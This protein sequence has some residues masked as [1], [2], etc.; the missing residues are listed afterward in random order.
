VRQGNPPRATSVARSM[1]QQRTYK[2]IAV[3]P[4]CRREYYEGENDCTTCR[5][6]RRAEPQPARMLQGEYDGS[7]GIRIV[8]YQL[9]A[10]IAL[11]FVVGLLDGL[12]KN[13]SPAMITHLSVSL[14]VL[15]VSA[16]YSVYPATVL[17]LSLLIVLVAQGL[18]H[19]FG[20]F[21]LGEWYVLKLLL[22][23]IPAGGILRVWLAR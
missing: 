6:E 12:L 9:Y 1:E 16:R 2:A 3:C 11:S 17:I 20:F 21:T 13:K 10:V 23:L 15:I 19:H 14:L 18:G 8:R 4:I 22:V 7:T 5:P